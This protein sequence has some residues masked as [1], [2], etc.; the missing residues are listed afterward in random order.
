M[1]CWIIRLARRLLRRLGRSGSRESG[2]PRLGRCGSKWEEA[3][4]C[5]G[6]A[7]VAAGTEHAEE[8]DAAALDALAGLAGYE[9][10]QLY[11]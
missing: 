8:D 3:S 6:S 4:C 9:H 2:L 10:S 11:Q 7:G 1:S 5:V